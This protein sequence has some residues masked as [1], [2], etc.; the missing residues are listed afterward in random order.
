MRVITNNHQVKIKLSKK[1][2]QLIKQIKSFTSKIT[3]AQL[4][5]V[6]TDYSQRLID[7]SLGYS[8]ASGFDF[9]KS[10]QIVEYCFQNQFWNKDLNI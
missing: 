5:N 1:Q 3:P 7:I 9:E 6:G 4:G 2:K 10:N 8:I